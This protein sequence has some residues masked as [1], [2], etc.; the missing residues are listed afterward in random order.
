MCK[1]YPRLNP[2]HHTS[3][4][5]WE[6]VKIFYGTWADAAVEEGPGSITIA[7]LLD[8]M[9]WMPPDMI[10]SNL[11]RVVANMDKK[12]GRIFWRSFA[13]KVHSPVLAHLKVRRGRLNISD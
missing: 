1:T 5:R 7:S 6:R 4:R 13:D 10:A 8:S 3:T 11:E 12:K 9:D 2:A